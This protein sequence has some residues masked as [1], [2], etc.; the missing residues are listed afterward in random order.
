MRPLA[1]QGNASAVSG[2]ENWTWLRADLS[3]GVSQHVLSECDIRF[4]NTLLQT[5]VHHRF[6]A[7]GDFFSRLEQCDEGSAPRLRSLGEELGCTQQTRHMR[8]MTASMCD[9]DC[10]PRV[11]NS[12]E[13]RSIRQSGVFADRKCVHVSSLE[14][15]LAFAIL[16]DTNDS[17]ATNPIDDLVTEL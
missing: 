9:T 6:G 11:I 12:R 1:I 2:R 16:Q 4:R 17:G 3:R 15:G 10:V 13:C 5:V 14:Y 8:V 7:A